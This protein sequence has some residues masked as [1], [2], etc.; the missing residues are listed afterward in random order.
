MVLLGC[1]PGST[2]EEVMMRLISRR[3]GVEFKGKR[4]DPRAGADVLRHYARSLQ[5]C[6]AEVGRAPTNTE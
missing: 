1:A 4:R 6:W 5:E 3:R 2:P